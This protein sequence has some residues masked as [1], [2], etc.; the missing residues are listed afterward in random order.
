MGDKQ[1]Q[2]EELLLP[3]LDAAYNVAYWL[4]Q[5]DADAQKIVQ[6]AFEQA[7]KEFG[8]CADVRR[9]LLAFVLRAAHAWI[10]QRS[11]PDDRSPIEPIVETHGE[12]GPETLSGALKKLPLELREVLVLHELEGWS[13]QEI[14]AALEIPRTAVAA[15]LS[16]ARRCLCNELQPAANE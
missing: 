12:A 16:F 2:F 1:S 9:R 3:H 15:R 6:K 13:Y 7:C 14:A 8:K 5:N 10:R 4:I 11:R